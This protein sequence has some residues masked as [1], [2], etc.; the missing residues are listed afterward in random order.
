MHGIGTVLV[1]VFTK[2][3]SLSQFGF[4]E[5]MSQT[6]YVAEYIGSFMDLFRENI[7]N[8]LERKRN[9]SIRYFSFFCFCS[10]L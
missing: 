10:S 7:F 5:K 8:I 2:Y 4:S 3:K 1:L 6:V 9:C